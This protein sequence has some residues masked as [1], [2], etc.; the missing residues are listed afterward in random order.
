MNDILF[1]GT[2]S[3]LLAVIFTP[4]A[5][6]VAAHLNLMDQ[7]D[8]YRK[9]HKTP[10]PRV[11]G[12]AVTLACLAAFGLT[13]AGYFGFGAGP[14]MAPLFALA[15]KIAPA[16]AIIVVLGLLD[17]FFELPAR[18]K[19]AGQLLAALTAY[20]SGIHVEY[21]SG[22]LAA[23]SLN[24]LITVGWLVACCNAMNFI[25]GIDGAAAGIG[26]IAFLTVAAFALLSGDTALALM[27]ILIA[28][29]LLGFLCFNFHPASVFLG[30]CGSLSIGFVL[31]CFG[32]L[33]TQKAATPL[34]HIAPVFVLMIPLADVTLAI[35][36][37]AMAGKSI[38]AAD[39]NHVHHRLLAKGLPVRT[40]VTALYAACIAASAVA[41][42]QSTVSTLTASIITVV[43]AFAFTRS[44]GFLGY[45]QPESSRRDAKPVGKFPVIIAG[46]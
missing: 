4:V 16:A 23:E 41:L 19:L 7:P 21:F 18:T 9:I 35:I 33:W 28:A 36:R 13:A 29:G 5:T 34:G 32:L 17:D 15:W 2:L 43:F 14:D 30:D 45:A 39:A 8:N 42:L 26:T 6:T 24:L 40:A 22:S 38:F 27:S 25:D 37:R 10:I 12:A 46:D 11:G 3:F 44:I 31:G 1:L 20:N